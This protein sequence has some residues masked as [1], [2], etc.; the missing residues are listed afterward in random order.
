MDGDTQTPLHLAACYNTAATVP[1]L[2]ASGADRE[3]RDRWAWTPIF[4]AVYRDYDAVFVLLR[5]GGA[6]MGPGLVDHDSMTLLHWAVKAGA[7]KIL[8]LLLT[9]CPSLSLE[10]RDKWGWTPIFWAVYR[11]YDSMFI[12]LRDAGAKASGLVDNDSMTLLHW[13][14]KAGAAKAL[15]LLLGAGPKV[16][17]ENRD[18]WG[19]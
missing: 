8:R 12:L 10:D 13:A 14:V 7:L 1:P 15:R 17:L 6:K 4:W 16:S 18:K 5:D 3:A 9:A 2:L 19:W 11:D